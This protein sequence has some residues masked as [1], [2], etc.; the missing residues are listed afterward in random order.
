MFFTVAI[1]ATVGLFSYQF[2]FSGVS[3]SDAE[4]LFD[5][6]PNQSFSSVSE[7]LEKSMLIKN[8]WAFVKYAQFKSLTKK[9]KV[10]EYSLNQSM[11]PDQILNVLISGKSVARKLTIIEGSNIFD[12]A[13]LMEKNKISTREEFLLLIRNKEFIKKVINEDL[14]SLEGYLFPETYQ[15]T[16]FEKLEDIVNQMVKRFLIVWTEFEE[17]SKLRLSTQN[18]PRHKIINLASIIEKET[19]FEK[20]RANVS[21]VFH[22]RLVQNMKLQTDPTV[23]YGMAVEQNTNAKNISKADLLRPTKYNTYTN[24]GLPLTPISNPGRKAIAATLNPATTKYL[25]FVSKN[26]GTTAFSESLSD[27]N[28]AVQNYQIN[29]KAREGKSWRDLQKKK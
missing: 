15:Y 24:Y 5:L 17:E 8:K 2:L 23:L 21:S 27:H 7:N 10:G 22:N 14:L 18:W 19:G 1:V 25:Y 4:I 13:D 11:T 9:I 28:S 26:D 20:D 12:V 3:E 16:K 6:E 29:N